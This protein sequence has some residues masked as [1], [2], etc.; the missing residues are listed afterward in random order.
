[1]KVSLPVLS[2]LNRVILQ[3]LPKR[4]FGG[5]FKKGQK[6]KIKSFECQLKRNIRLAVVSMAVFYS[7]ILFIFNV[8]RLSVSLSQ[9]FSA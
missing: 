2:L 5:V 9:I 8:P 3:G 7:F 4:K 1:M 6:I